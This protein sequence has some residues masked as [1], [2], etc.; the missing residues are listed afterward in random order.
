M[1]KRFLIISSISFLAVLVIDQISKYLIIKKIPETGIFLLEDF[2]SFNL[3]FN[4][5]IGFGLLLP[6]WTITVLTVGLIG[7]LVYLL[8]NQ[9]KQRLYLTSFL[10][11][12][13][14]A[15]A[16]SNFTD[17][18]FRGGVVD[19]VS[20]QINSFTWPSFN[21]ADIVI[22]VSAIILIFITFNKNSEK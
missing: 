13:V 22:T 19:F 4:Y 11:S 7:L 16:L 17:R 9:I 15:A 12:L 18:L 14:T 21:F 10:I 1:K 20:I 8:I 3:T 6:S 2:L 5:G